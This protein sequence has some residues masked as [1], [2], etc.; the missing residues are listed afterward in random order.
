[1]HS[2]DKQ[3][4]HRLRIRWPGREQQLERLTTLF[5]SDNAAALPCTLVYGPSSTGKTSVVRYRGSVCS[6]L[7]GETQWSH[8]PHTLNSYNPELKR[9]QLTWLTL[10][11]CSA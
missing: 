6:Q 8:L 4:F 1:M 11:G 10:Q 5:S 3:A 7:F 2:K 9:F